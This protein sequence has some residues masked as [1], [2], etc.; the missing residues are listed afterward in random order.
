MK[1][2]R[3]RSQSE[4][5]VTRTKVTLRHASANRVWRRAE[6]DEPL[7]SPRLMDRSSSRRRAVRERERERQLVCG[8]R[9][10]TNTALS[11]LL[12]LATA[13]LRLSPTS[14]SECRLPF[15]TACPASLTPP[16]PTPD[17]P[18]PPLRTPPS[19]HHLA[20]PRLTFLHITTA[21]ACTLHQQHV[22]A[23][24]TVVNPGAY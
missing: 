2:S 8:N 20:W 18:A 17:S 19:L 13:P 12:P 4:V 5:Q 16:T 14:N 7:H 3:L 22:F 10:A 9:S 15:T 6:G 23:S 21:I 24:R 11:P 1:S